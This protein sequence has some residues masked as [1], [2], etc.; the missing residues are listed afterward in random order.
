MTT[1]PA[2]H[3]PD[4]APAVT[5]PG[6][7]GRALRTTAFW[8]F[9]SLLVLVAAFGALSQNHVFFNLSNI[10]TMA[11]NASELLLLAVGMSFLLGA[12]QLDLSIGSNLTLASVLAAR[13]ITA[14]AGKC[15]S[16]SFK[17]FDNLVFILV[18][19]ISALSAK[20]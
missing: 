16:R 7:F 4:K 5:E 15:A 3:A 19:G 8:M 18:G 13:T 14:L 12:G 20:P 17:S 2:T 6:V 1:L 9:V 11:L 10:F